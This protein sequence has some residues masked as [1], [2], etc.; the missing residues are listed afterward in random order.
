[1]DTRFSKNGIR[2]LLIILVFLFV[3]AVPMAALAEPE[4]TAEPETDAQQ[5]TEAA[6]SVPKAHYYDI[7]EGLTDDM[8]KSASVVMLFD[9]ETGEEIYSKNP[10][11]RVFPASTTKL[12]TALIA[13]EDGLQD[14]NVTVKVCADDFSSDNSLMGL[15]R[16]AGTQR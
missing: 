9:A 11:K 14:R 15:V 12:L 7:S 4:T 8:F 16:N 2:T 13:E 6:P 1:M 10:D 3:L 5:E